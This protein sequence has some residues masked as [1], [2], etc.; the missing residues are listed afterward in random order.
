MSYP[1]VVGNW[2]MNTSLSEAIILGGQAERTAESVKHLDIVICPPSVFLYP[3]YERLRARPNNLYFGIQNIMWEDEGAFTGEISA[4]MIHGVCRFVIIGHSERRK[5]FSETDEMVNKKV[6][7]S[8]SK[9]LVPVICV[10]EQERFHLEDHYQSEISRMKKQSGILSQIEKALDGVKK[11]DLDKVV[12]SYEPIWAIGTGNAATG[13][14]AAAIC[15]IVKEQLTVMFGEDAKSVRLLYGGSVSATNIKEFMMQPSIDG[16]LVGGAS[17]K[18]SEFA[19]ICQITS[20]VKS[21]RLI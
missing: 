3:V 12:I 14:Y 13:A 7:F 5:I 2:K 17:L 4:S 19:K 1:L 21:G 6:L 20:E 8:L 15:H 10:G 9:G 11:S 18:S 16:L